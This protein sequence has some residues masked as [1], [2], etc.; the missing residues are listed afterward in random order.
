MEDRDIFNQEGWAEYR[1]ECEERFAWYD[2]TYFAEKQRG[3]R[4]D[5]QTRELPDL[6]PLRLNPI[7]KFIN[8]HKAV[9]AGIQED[10]TEL[11]VSTVVDRKGLS[12]DQHEQADSIE[13]F[14]HKVWLG[15]AGLSSMIESM[16]LIQI[17]GGH[18][19]QVA[20]QPYDPS[21]TYGINIISH[22]S[23]ARMWPTVWNATRT[24]LLEA[25]IGYYI[26]KR[27]ALIRFGIEAENDDVLYLERWTPEEYWIHVDGK[28]PK[29]K[30]GDRVEEYKGKNLWGRVPLAYIP[31]DRAGGLLGMSVVD[32]PQTLIGLAKE[33]NARMA[34]EGDAA[35]SAAQHILTARNLGGGALSHRPIKDADGQTTHVA[36]DLGSRKP[37]PNAGDPELLYVSAAGLP[38][39]AA[40]FSD[41]IWNAI[42]VQGDVASVALGMDDTVSGRISGPVTAYRMLPTLVHT[43]TE[44]LHYSTGLV[45]VGNIALAIARQKIKDGAYQ[46]L[47]IKPPDLPDFE[48]TLLTHWMP[49]IPIEA[50][51][52]VQF[53][54]ARLQA[55]GISLYSYLQELG[56]QDPAREEE[57]I[58]ADYERKVEIEERA[59]AQV[60][61]Q[62]QQEQDDDQS[63]RDVRRERQ[64]DQDNSRDRQ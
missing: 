59:K 52:R 27:E 9:M 63:E 36:V 2:G 1:S 30:I 18:V 42:M 31:H 28:V 7:A 14:L 3:A 61:M 34:D 20:W 41:D 11:P 39:S 47:G 29:Y 57:R 17:Y 44:R 62:M 46:Q 24:Q 33:L 55:G 64:P 5:S 45:Q 16:L 60:M 4:R 32:G 8:I 23:P 19:F 12:E 13:L 43:V 26:S 35:Q 51:Q 54:N 56:C 49:E 37:M 53:N 48:P 40:R 21:A 22:C 38:E 10:I 25:Y 15:S 6:W 58:W 50:E